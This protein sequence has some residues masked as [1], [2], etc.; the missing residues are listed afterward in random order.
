MNVT[1]WRWFPLG[2]A[3]A[4][5]CAVAVNGIMVYAACS[6]FPGVAGADGFD[7]SNQYNRVL[8]AARQQGELGWQIAADAPD[9]RSPVLRLS[10]SDGS[11]L[12]VTS[13]T[14]RAERPVGPVDA[15][16]LSFHQ[17]ADQ[18]YRTDTSLP[19]GQWDIMLTILADGRSFSATRRIVVK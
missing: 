17:G 6:G 15:I 11:P 13:I 7:L 1:R 18:G 14:A 19:A 3:A 8:A 2:L 12:E 10:A 16:R 4:M 9:S 5:G